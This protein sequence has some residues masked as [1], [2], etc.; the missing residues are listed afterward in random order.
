MAWKIGEVA[1]R[2]GLTARALHFYEEQGLIGPIS[3]NSAGHRVYTQSDLF[4]LQQI[5]SLRL[6]GVSL[7]DIAPSLSDPSQLV[8]QLKQQL[9]Q[10]RQQRD[11]IQSVEDRISRL[12]NEL[13]TQ[14]LPF[15]GLDEILFQ[16]L[17]SMTMYDKYFNQTK[18]DEMHSHG[19][20]KDGKLSIEDAW[21]QWVVSM[22]TAIRS[23]SDPKS[24][25]VQELMNHWGDMV[26]HITENDERQLQAFNDLLHNEPQARKDHGISDDLFNN[27]AKAAGGH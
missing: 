17:E 7:A 6:L 10:L 16:T 2:T 21:N 26:D 15:D 23:G 3:R 9:T 1:D 18:V 12:I 5:R 11:A 8:P 20:H 19:H 24:N 13:E 27:M 22:E 14:S 25:E 4:R